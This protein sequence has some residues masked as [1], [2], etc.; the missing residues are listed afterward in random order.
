MTGGIDD[1]INYRI[2]RAFETIK[3]AESMIENEFWNA[4]INRLYYACFYAVSGLLEKTN[5]LT[6]SGRFWLTR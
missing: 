5:N 4:S 3:E 2:S 6:T 1:L